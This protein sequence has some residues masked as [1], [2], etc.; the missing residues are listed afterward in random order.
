MKALL[1][2]WGF[3]E[4][5]EMCTRGRVRS[6]ETSAAQNG[7]GPCLSDITDAGYNRSPGYRSQKTLGSVKFMAA[8]EAWDAALPLAPVWV[9]EWQLA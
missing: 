3:G 8:A 9:L 4:D 5:A 7:L 1:S 2:G 6:P